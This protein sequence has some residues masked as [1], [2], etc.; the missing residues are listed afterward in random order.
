M[1]MSLDNPTKTRKRVT[2]KPDTAVVPNQTH[3][4]TDKVA[5]YV[6]KPSKEPIGVV[7]NPDTGA[8]HV[9]DG[10]HRITADRLAGRSTKAVYWEF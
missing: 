9:L 1:E 7:K 3:V 5:E 2:I 6:K 10:H 4:H 8:L